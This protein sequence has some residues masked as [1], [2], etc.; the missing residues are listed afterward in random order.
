MPEETYRIYWQGAT[1]AESDAICLTLEDHLPHNDSEW[2][3]KNGYFEFD[4]SEWHA[5]A[6]FNEAR[7]LCA[8]LYQAYGRRIAFEIRKLVWQREVS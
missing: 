2:D 6:L 5:G 1:M 3:D 8:T 7:D 4:E